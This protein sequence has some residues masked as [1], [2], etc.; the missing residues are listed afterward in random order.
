M[1]NINKS[2]LLFILIF[3][4]QFCFPLDRLPGGS[5]YTGRP[6]DPEADYFTPENFNITA[7][8]KTDVAAI[9][10]ISIINKLTSSPG[11]ILQR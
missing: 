3:S 4:A 9:W 8:G 10:S 7:D 2:S 5:F 11:R 1:K 6:A